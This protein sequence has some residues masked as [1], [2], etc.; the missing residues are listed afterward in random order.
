MLKKN[1]ELTKI[2]HEQGSFV[3]PKENW[4]LESCLMMI[5]EDL[6]FNMEHMDQD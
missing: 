2:N 5:F 4:G 1:E 6:G 3:K